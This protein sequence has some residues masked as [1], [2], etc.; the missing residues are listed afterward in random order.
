ELACL[1]RCWG[2]LPTDWMPQERKT[3]ILGRIE[4]FASE[5]NGYNINPSAKRGTVYGC[6]IS[7]HAYQDLN[8]KLPNPNGMIDCIESLRTTDGGYANEPQLPIGAVP[9]TAAAI[10]ISHQLNSPIDKTLAKWLANCHH[11]NGGF[12]A[13]PILDEPDLLSTAVALHAL[14]LINNTID[15]TD[16]INAITPP[17][18]TYLT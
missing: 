15:I 11:P 7:L 8:T 1:A 12:L 4:T 18:H 6:F 2:N 16:I 5:D 13:I 10:T 3:K 14:T 9:S 17:C